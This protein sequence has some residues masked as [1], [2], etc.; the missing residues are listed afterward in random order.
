MV[1]V[2]LVAGIT[3]NDNAGSQRTLSQRDTSASRFSFS[4]SPST[5]ADEKREKGKKNSKKVRPVRE[6]KVGGS[7]GDFGA[8]S[9]S[10]QICCRRLRRN[11]P[12]SWRRSWRGCQGCLSRFDLDGAGYGR[13]RAGKAGSCHCR[14][15]CRLVQVMPQ[16][17]NAS[18][19]ECG[20]D[21]KHLRPILR[22]AYESISLFEKRGSQ[23]RLWLDL[24][25][26]SLV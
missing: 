19:R 16:C 11:G 15:A 25:A 8:T 23:N 26:W 7:L 24:L 13:V 6:R 1:W 14:G 18:M 22:A 4:F 3:N 21:R 20:V 2:E 9:P 5:E 12:F 17:L 10:A